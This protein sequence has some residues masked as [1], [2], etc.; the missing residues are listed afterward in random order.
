VV[1]LLLLSAFEF[2]GYSGRSSAML[3]GA[4]VPDGQHSFILNPALSMDADRVQTGVVY[5]RPYGL[6][7]LAWSRICAGWSSQRLAAGLGLSGLSLDRYRE[8]DVQV[9]VG[10]MPAPGFAVGLGMHALIIEAGPNLS[11]FVPAFDAGVCWR[12]G[13]IRAGAAGLR[14]NSPRWRDGSELPPRLVLAGSWQP[15][16]EVMLAIDVGRE[17]SDEDAAFG[18]EF[19]LTPQLGLRFGVGAAPLRFAAGLGAR[20]G[21]VGFE[22]AYQF[23]PVLKESHV[24]G[25]RAAWR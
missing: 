22:Y 23:H 8:R 20:A 25:L 9:V 18:A 21:P 1:L 7:G 14:L 4:A 24:F 15:V 16:D 12:S 19:R 10:G 5:S 3:A 11:D 6:P 13:R 17:R 2:P